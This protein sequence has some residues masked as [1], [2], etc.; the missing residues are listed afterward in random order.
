MKAIIYHLKPN[1]GMS[2]SLQTN[3]KSNS[4]NRTPA[5][6][7]VSTPDALAPPTAA[8][9]TPPPGRHLYKLGLDVDLDQLTTTIQCDHQTPKPPRSFTPQTLITW[10]Q[11][12]VAAG[13]L[14]WTV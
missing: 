9:V 14:V 1:H 7:S 3:H 13:H 4:A 6:P 2:T 11:Q 5:K 10:V 8:Q 12:Q